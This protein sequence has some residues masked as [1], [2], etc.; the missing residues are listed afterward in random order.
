MNLKNGLGHRASNNKVYSRD[1]VLS[2]LTTSMEGL[3]QKMAT[4]RIRDKSRFLQRL[5]VARTLAYTANIYLGGIRDNELQDVMA[6]LT[7]LEAAVADAPE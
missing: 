5:K 6:E 2:L 4:G 3:A 7:K 1:D